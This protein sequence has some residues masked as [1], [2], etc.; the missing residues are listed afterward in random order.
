MRKW[1]LIALT[2]LPWWAHA[3]PLR[4]VTLDVQNMSC[5]ICPITVKRALTQVPGVAA[6]KIDFASKT[7]QVT[8]DPAIAPEEALTQA[9]TDA[10]Y[11]ATVREPSP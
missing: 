7:A 9:S 6:V 11:P 3:A 8:F 2:V 5:E 1:L 4:T 10:G